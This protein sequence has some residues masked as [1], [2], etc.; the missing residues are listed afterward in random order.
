MPILAINGNPVVDGFSTTAIQ[1]GIVPLSSWTVQQVISE[2]MVL[3]NTLDNEDD[4]FVENVRYHYNMN[5]SHLADLLNLS[6]S[7]FYGMYL[8]GI[9]E[10]GFHPFGGIHWIDL[11]GERS[12]TSIQ[13][14]NTANSAGALH[15][16][17]T[18]PNVSLMQKIHS[19]KAVTINLRTAVPLPAT[20]GAK[21]TFATLN[22][23]FNYTGNIPKWTLQQILQQANH[24]NN[25]YRQTLAYC[26]HGEELLFFVGS[27]FETPLREAESNAPAY[28][29]IAPTADNTGHVFTI[30][31][32]RQPILDNLLPISN[33]ATGS[34]ASG[35]FLKA[36]IPDRY[37]KL[38]VDMMRVSILQQAKQSVPQELQVGVNTALAQIGQ[39][40]E[41]AARL[42]QQA[43]LT[44]Q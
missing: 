31:C 11:G 34:T 40:L 15:P 36:D 43:K 25:Q 21:V 5:L 12:N 20:Y 19:I 27:Q 16:G 28:K 39:N 4:V 2:A 9:F 38:L 24:L 23:Q 8:S 18:N 14:A 44:N 22:N 35:F 32:Y 3:T 13:V 30:W 37:I 42:E 10:T 6:A 1:Q 33:G 41:Q 17:T 7:P 29:I 26:H